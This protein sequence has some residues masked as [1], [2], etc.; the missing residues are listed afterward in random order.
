MFIL[1]INKIDNLLRRIHS[2]MRLPA[3]GTTLRKA[4]SYTNTFSVKVEPSIKNSEVPL[5]IFPDQDGAKYYLGLDFTR[6]IRVDDTPHEITTRS[7]WDAYDNKVDISWVI[8]TKRHLVVS[9]VEAIATFTNETGG[10]TIN[11]SDGVTEAYFLNPFTGE[12]DISVPA[13][14][15]PFIEDLGRVHAD[16]LDFILASQQAK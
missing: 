4:G 11:L 9:P 15:I 10:S 8:P 1:A 6:E 5:V 7:I 2:F 12:Y 16:V 3:V 14:R 13:S